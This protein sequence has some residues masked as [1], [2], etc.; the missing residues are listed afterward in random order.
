M[1]NQFHNQAFLIE[2]N[3]KYA[4]ETTLQNCHN[5]RV[6]YYNIIFN[7]GI[8][9]IFVTVTFLILYYSY[10]PPL[11][12]EEK[13]QKMIKDQQYVL[14]KIRF[15]KDEFK[16][17]NVTDITSLPVLPKEHNIL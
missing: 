1:F 3:V 6:K 11:T 5:C 12:Y 14:S 17:K 10:K 2:P 9:I 4:L 13:Q 15:Y 8:F 7:A 16:K